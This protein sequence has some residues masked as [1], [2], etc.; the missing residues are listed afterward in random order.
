MTRFRQDGKWSEGLFF[1]PLDGPGIHCCPSGMRPGHLITA[2]AVVIT[3]PFLS[4]RRSPSISNP[5]DNGNSQDIR[6]K[7]PELTPDLAK[8]TLIE[9]IRSKGILDDMDGALDALE[10]AAPKSTH[11]DYVDFGLWTFNPSKRTFAMPIIAPPL[12][13]SYEG[14]FRY[15]KDAWKAEIT[16]ETR[17]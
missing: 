3:L 5:A 1:Q 14:E 10:A 6:P 8:R 2:L 17:N 7:Q 16:K 13:L 11:D 12:F 4:C 9:M 15:E